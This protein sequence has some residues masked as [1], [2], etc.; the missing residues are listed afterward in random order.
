MDEMNTIGIVK[1]NN[2]IGHAGVGFVVIPDGVDVDAYIQDCYRNNTITLWGGVG[3]G[4]FSDVCV[5]E[6]VMQQI[7]FPSN[8]E[9]FNRG[10]AVVWV[11]DDTSQ[12]PV[13]VASL[14]NPEYYFPLQPNQWRMAKSVDDKRIVELFMDADTA[15]IVINISG[16]KDD[17]GDLNIKVTS[18]KKDSVINVECDNVINI[19]GSNVNVVATNQSSV[20][21]S[22]DGIT[23]SSVT[24]KI[25]EGVTAKI[26]KKA[27]VSIVDEDKEER[28]KITYEIEK[29]VEYADEFDNSV[30]LADGE[31]KVKIADDK[32]EISYKKDEGFKYKDQFNNE[33]IC[34]NGEIKVK[35]Q[36]IKEE[37]DIQFNNGT[38]PMVK[39]QTLMQWLNDLCTA[40]M[41]LTV[42]TPM[43]PSGV[44]INAAQFGAL[45][46]QL[47]NIL[48]QRAKLE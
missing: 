16:D 29:G 1:V 23:Q 41:A 34:A 31:M 32:A 15:S 10:S 3:Y 17:A 28:A 25:D 46:G 12:R 14:R 2:N 45:R 22:K 27:E 21:L 33:L 44:P 42:T 11:K 24:C 38:E 19:T 8:P 18:E 6:S 40:I 9:K 20:V 26:L 37:G 7:Q 35:G 48:S 36:T 13:V 5:D 47:Q 43:G 30:I 39:G 4:Y